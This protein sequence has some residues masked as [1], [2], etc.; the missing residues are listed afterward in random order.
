MM[1][2]DNV[3][4]GELQYS[5][6]EELAMMGIEDEQESS[7]VT[8]ALEVLSNLSDA[9]NLMATGAAATGREVEL[10]KVIANMSVAGTDT[11]AQHVG[12]AM[13]SLSLANAR[14]GINDMYSGVVAKIKTSINR[15][16]DTF[17]T[18]L[19]ALVTL[20]TVAKTRVKKLRTA[21]TQV[22]VSGASKTVSAISLTHP[23]QSIFLQGVRYPKNMLEY[24]AALTQAIAALSELINNSHELAVDS[25]GV[26]NEFKRSFNLDSA[27][28]NQLLV[29]ENKYKEIW[30]KT[31]GKTSGL[32]KIRESENTIFKECPT[33]LGGYRI[34]TKEPFIS[35]S[36]DFWG[37]DSMRLSNY[38][39]FIEHDKKPTSATSLVMSVAELGELDKTINLLEELLDKI[40]VATGRLGSIKST[41]STV[42]KDAYRDVDKAYT[43]YVQQNK[44]SEHGLGR[45]TMEIHAPIVRDLYSAQQRA[46][47]AV[48]DS[49][50]VASKLIDGGYILVDKH[51]SHY[52]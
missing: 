28:E 26:V 30:N 34:S 4:V 24:Q 17:L 44:E 16:A 43:N 37:S 25:A 21:I 45:N 8:H 18:S 9:N 32:K 46:S 23:P 36:D 22:K 40:T 7:E 41:L 19:A 14:V 33:L 31:I 3:Q 15:G 39:C 13:E 6:Y 10:L 5:T 29:L 27:P 1:T 52:K 47:H 48:T 35:S 11:P 20:S 38:G 50:T 2:E 51:L 49:L 12:A 42:Y